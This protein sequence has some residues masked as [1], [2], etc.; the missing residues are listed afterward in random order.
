MVRHIIASLQA[1]APAFPALPE[2]SHFELKRL[3]SDIEMKVAE[4]PH[5]DEDTDIDLGRARASRSGSGSI[6]AT[7]E[8]VFPSR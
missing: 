7:A 8:C 2:G 1:A 4:S 3:V 6:I 5:V